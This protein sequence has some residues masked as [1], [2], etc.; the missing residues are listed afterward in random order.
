MPETNNASHGCCCRFVSNVTLAV[1]YSNHCRLISPSLPSPVSL[2]SV[3]SRLPF[4]DPG[5]AYARTVQPP[6]D[7]PPHSILAAPTIEALRATQLWKLG[8]QLTGWCEQY[9]TYSGARPAPLTFDRWLLN[10]LPRGPAPSTGIDGA[11]GNDGGG[12]KPP[13]QQQQQQSAAPDSDP[14]LHAGVAAVAAEEHLVADLVRA[15]FTPEQARS[16]AGK[17][18][19]ASSAAV[20]VVRAAAKTK[21]KQ[22]KQKQKQKQKQDQ[23]PGGSGGKPGPAKPAAGGDGSDV[24]LN[25]YRHSIAVSLRGKEKRALKLNHEHYDKLRALFMWRHGGDGDGDGDGDAALQPAFEAALYSLLQRYSS[26]DGFGFQAACPEQ[27]HLV[28][29]RQLGVSHEC[30]ASPLN[31]FFPSY[32]SAFPDTDASF[33]S[34]GSFWDWVPGPA[35]GAFE[36][37]PPFV[38]DVML[39]MAAR[40]DLLLQRADTA[41]APLTFA[42]I[43]PGWLDDPGVAR[44]VSS[45][46]TRLRLD[47]P[48]EDHG[49]CDGAQHMRRDRYR[50]SPYDTLV[51]VMQSAAAR[52]AQPVAAGQGRKALTSALMDAFAHGAPTDAA[53]YRRKR[54][55]RGLGDEDGGGGVYK[56]KRANKNTKKVRPAD[57]AGSTAAEVKVTAKAK[58]S[59]VCT[60]FLSPQGCQ[61][62]AKCRFVHAK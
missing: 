62:G 53:V 27:V 4:L 29:Q 34:C 14:L 25:H 20:A 5:P 40:M 23:T 61:K 52:D 50:A 31:T 51:F 22:Q 16:I 2:L 38:A 35:G 60:H 47:V 18:T 58:L 15:S 1:I 21:A 12:G 26:L 3:H 49:F 6:A 48:K 37:N 7:A 46:Y 32:C 44:L 24:V 19:A 56:G 13:P 42:V 30:F 43:V 55:G 59:N 45:P 39:A 28:L 36:A 57:S 9:G 8:K 54:D 33:G 17:L 10:G 41:G 11:R